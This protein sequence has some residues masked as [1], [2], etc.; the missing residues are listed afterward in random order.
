MANRTN[1]YPDE[2]IEDVLVKV[3]ELVFPADFYVLDMNDDYSPNPSPLLLGRPFRSTS[4]TK[5]DINK[6]ILSM[7]FDEKIVHFNIF[8]V[9]NY[10]STSGSN[11]IFSMSVIDPV[12]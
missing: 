3:N 8:E 6:G 1:A 4:Q 11:S 2:L 5:I 12:V 7:K 10:L 9:I